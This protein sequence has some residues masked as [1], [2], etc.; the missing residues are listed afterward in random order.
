MAPVALTEAYVQ[1]PGVI[2]ELFRQIRQGQAPSQFTVQHLKDL[3]YGSSNHR[4]FLPL[5]KALGFLTADGTPTAR[6]SEYRDETQSRRVLA[7]A[8]KQAYADVFVLRSKPSDADRALFEGKFK[9]THNTSDR[10]AKL[11][12][13]T[14]FALL[15]LADLDA[16]PKPADTGEQKTEV[17]ERDE[18][19]KGE[20]QGQ[21][22]TGRRAATSL[23]Y[24]I[25]IHLPATKDIEVYNSIF[26]SLREH[27]LD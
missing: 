9:S 12:A 27:L 6:Y 24:N 19:G 3:G 23:H 7:D 15:P 16:N 26:K 25:Q 21:R 5:L 10:M 8:L 4:L 17:V 2:P 22:G 11:M 18:A 20:D 14:F 13:S 1:T